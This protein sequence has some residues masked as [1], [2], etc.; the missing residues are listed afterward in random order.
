MA[1][2]TWMKGARASARTGVGMVVDT[3]FVALATRPYVPTRSNV[4][5][6]NVA[7][8]A[9]VPVAAVGT[10]RPLAQASVPSGSVLVSIAR[11]M[12]ALVPEVTTDCGYWSE[13]TIATWM[14][15]GRVR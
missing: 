4:H 2:P 10:E 12:V 7:I 14:S 11:V 5:P 1:V 15:N 9:N 3:T 6:V 13:S 8:P